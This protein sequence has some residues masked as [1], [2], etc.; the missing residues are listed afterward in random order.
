[1]E[2]I[3]N[4]WNGKNPGLQIQLVK[5]WDYWIRDQYSTVVKT[6]QA[7]LK[8]WREEFKKVEEPRKFSQDPIESEDAWGTLEI[9]STF[10]LLEDVIELD[11]EG[12]KSY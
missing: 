9:L 5:S 3:E 12:L 4:D 8:L 7:W 1:M 11:T 2:L 10:E 6:A